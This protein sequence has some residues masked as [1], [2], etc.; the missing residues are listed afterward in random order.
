LPLPPSRRR[1]V[2]LL[3]SLA[4]ALGAGVAWHYAAAGLTLSHYDAK[5]HLVVARRVLDG[6]TPGWKQVGAVWLPLPHLLNLLPVQVD[7]WYRTGL[8]AVVMSV[9]SFATT[10]GLLSASV[11]RVTG[12]RLA[13]LGTAVV[14]ASDPNVLYLQ[15][16]PMT[17]PLMFAMLA[18]S[19][20]ATLSL[21]REGADSGRTWPAGLVL[22]LA[23]LT[24]YEAWPVTALL[25]GLAWVS[26]AR[27]RTAGDARAVIARVARWPLAAIALFIVNSRV[28]TGAWFVTGGF[29]VPEN[30][31]QGRPL[32]ALWQIGWGLVQLA[33][34]WTSALG[35]LGAAVALAWWWLPQGRARS[36]AVLALAIA[37][38]A[39]LPFYAF[40]SGHPF[41]IRYMVV[42]VLVAAV[43]NGLAIA[44]WPRRWMR[45]A[46]TT[47]VCG[48]AVVERPPLDASAPM[49]TEAQWDR[50]N[51]AARGA[52]TACLVAGFE[53][54]AHKILASMGS[55]AHY[56]QE[57]SRAGFRI[58]DFVHE[59]T[60]DIWPVTV[61][62]PRRHVEW[63]LFEERAEGGDEL[64]RRRL[65][66]PEL[67]EG[68]ERV[69]EG[70]GVALYR[71]ISRRD[72]HL[73]R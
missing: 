34:P 67:T 68:F 62:A 44:V 3:W 60:D 53:R 8:S 6:L 26:L 13:A 37:G 57:L 28:S 14:F 17:E 69:C 25:L 16:T 23:C 47:L 32:V 2:L 22:A 21:L 54:P 70:G 10:A 30:E 58:D 12:S 41:R 66:F 51:T 64:T 59:G 39:A 55:L 40:V 7:A 19:V 71:R 46:A 38:A 11:V 56:M 43:G 52:V 73:S 18:A 20:S 49:V 63:I 61:D 4:L 1:F 42:L 65:R 9:L 24:R 5:A 36:R 27:R 50:P 29:F 48:V 31:A 35:A 45:V 72:I 15:A 33:G